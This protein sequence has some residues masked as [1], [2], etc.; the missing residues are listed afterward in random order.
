MF[1]THDLVQIDPWRVDSLAPGILPAVEHIV[2]NL[3]SQMGHTNLIY[4]RKTHC[5]PYI[6]RIFIFHY[7]IDFVSN[8]AGRFLYIQ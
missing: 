4:L 5:K 6:H 8:V 2:Q 3:D 7:R 1:F